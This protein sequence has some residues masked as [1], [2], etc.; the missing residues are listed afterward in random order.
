M[1]QK[2]I[3]IDDPFAELSREHLMQVAQVARIRRLLENDMI[4]ADGHSAKDE[5]R[6]T[7]DLSSQG[8]EGKIGTRGK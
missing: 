2:P 8:I 1:P 4:P 3:E 6:Y 5:K 7:A